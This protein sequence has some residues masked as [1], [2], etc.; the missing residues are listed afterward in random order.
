MFFWK[1]GALDTKAFFFLKERLIAQKISE[2]HRVK[3]YEIVPL[4]NLP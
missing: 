4:T 2:I 3:N 1:Q